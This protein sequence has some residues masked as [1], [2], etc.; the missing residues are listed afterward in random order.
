MVLHFLQVIS[1]SRRVLSL[2]GV[3]I[4]LLAL[5]TWLRLKELKQFTANLKA[6]NRTFTEAEFTFICRHFAVPLLRW[7]ADLNRIYGPLIS[8]FI[9]STLPLNALLTMLLAFGRLKLLYR[10]VVYVFG[11]IQA[12]F[13][14]GLTLFAAKLA[15]EYQ[16]VTKRV[17]IHFYLLSSKTAEKQLEAGGSSM[18]MFRLQLSHFIVRFHTN[19]PYTLNLGKVGKLNFRMFGRIL[20]FYFKFLI[21][22]YK[23]MMVAK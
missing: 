17:L 21:F 22:A 16:K 6:K 19:N 4:S 10:L 1:I 7:L 2:V 9:L 8:G 3:F 13:L 12:L 5:T 20:F 14:F 15:A 23:L 11:A 18:T